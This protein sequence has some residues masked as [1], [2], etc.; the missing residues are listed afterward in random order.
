LLVPDR[1]DHIEA[2]ALRTRCRRAGLQLGT[3][4]TLLAWLCIRHGLTMLTTDGDFAPL[5]RL[6]KLKLWSETPVARRH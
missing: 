5:A 2:A 4:D 3:I 1:H 6:E